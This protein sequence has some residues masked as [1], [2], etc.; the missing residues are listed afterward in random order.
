M[1]HCQ[2]CQAALMPNG[3]LYEQL[4][5]SQGE[6]L[7]WP[8]RYKIAFGAAKGMSYLHHGCSPPIIHRD[9]KSYNILLDSELEAHIADFGLARIVEKLGQMN[10]MSGVAGTY[11]YIAPGKNL[12]GT[13]EVVEMQLSCSTDER[14]RKEATTT[15][16]PHLKRNP[17]DFRYASPSICTSTCPFND[18][19]RGID[20]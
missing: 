18:N 6:T 9:V 20:L 3:S 15:L 17:N 16:S 7:D 2:H 11:G 13:R 14:I 12:P 4:H 10:V 8:T 19:K 1:N 5:I